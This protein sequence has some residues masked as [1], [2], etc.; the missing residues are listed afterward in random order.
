MAES[1]PTRLA[2][3]AIE[4]WPE[5]TTLEDAMERLY[6]LGSIEQGRADVR[7]GRVTPHEDVVRRFTAP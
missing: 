5:D 1:S 3:H 4:Q 7:A 6:L 2:L